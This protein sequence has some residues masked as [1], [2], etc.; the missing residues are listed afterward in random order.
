MSEQLAEKLSGPQQPQATAPAD[1]PADDVEYALMLQ[2]EFD[3]E[4][5]GEGAAENETEDEDLALAMALQA[6]EE[7]QARAQRARQQRG[8]GQYQKGS[9]GVS[10]F[11]CKFGSFCADR[12]L[13]L[14]PICSDIHERGGGRAE[15]PTN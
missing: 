4:A 15:D 7:E 5:G 2:R 10:C 14:S 9:W 6:E 12:L 11:A 1:T 3:R 13:F 8:Q